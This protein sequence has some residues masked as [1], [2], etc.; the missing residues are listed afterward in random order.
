MTSSNAREG[1]P[2]G[3]Y[4]GDIIGWRG[5]FWALAPIGLVNLAWQWISLPPMAPRLFAGSFAT[6]RMRSP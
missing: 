4:L 1:A 2:I 3:S 5:I 6:L